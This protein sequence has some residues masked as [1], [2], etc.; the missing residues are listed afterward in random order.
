M[1]SLPVWLFSK[2]T[3]MVGSFSFGNRFESLLT[4]ALIITVIKPLIHLLYRGFKRRPVDVIAPQRLDHGARW[5]L[6]QADAF[7][8]RLGLQMHVGRK[9]GHRQ[10]LV[11]LVVDSL[12]HDGAH[13]NLLA[14]NTGCVKES[15]PVCQ[16]LPACRWR[17]RTCRPG[18]CVPRWRCALRSTAR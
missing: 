13:L 3:A 5:H 9:F 4:I 6:A 18:G 2:P 11:F 7:I 14:P 17:N 12:W 15:P 10:D 8:D 16:A 1:I